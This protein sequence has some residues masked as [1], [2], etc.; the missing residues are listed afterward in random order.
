MVGLK[1]VNGVTIEGS[2]V[3]VRPNCTTDYNSST[4]IFIKHVTEGTTINDFLPIISK[5]GTVLSAYIPYDSI[6]KK[7]KGI[8]YVDYDS[9]EAAKTAI[10]Q[11]NGK[12][13][14]KG[15]STL[16]VLPYQPLNRSAGP[17]QPFGQ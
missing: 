9:S 13:S 11:M 2:V 10:E 16:L 6:L 12:P 14:P 3:R 7:S 17:S 4:S 1:A 15:D 5:F 8:A